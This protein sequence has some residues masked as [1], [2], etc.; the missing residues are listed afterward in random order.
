MWSPRLHP[1]LRFRLRTQ[2]HNSYRYSCPLLQVCT[3]FFV[4]ETL[5]LS[6][7]DACKLCVTNVLSDAVL[8]CR[9][10]M[11]WRVCRMSQCVTA[12]NLHWTMILVRLLGISWDQ[13]ELFGINGYARSCFLV[14]NGIETVTWSQSCHWDAGATSNQFF[15]AWMNRSGGQNAAGK[16]LFHDFNVMC[17]CQVFQVGKDVWCNELL[18]LM[19]CVWDYASLTQCWRFVGVWCV[20]CSVSPAPRRST[21]GFGGAIF[22]I[23]TGSAGA[24]PWRSH[25]DPFGFTLLG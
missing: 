18:C 19:W 17:V 20:P 16:L 7:T 3:R 11:V 23:E 24:W 5:M 9:S 2:N 14:Q 4:D 15:R 13:F 22:Q 10:E 6:V 25:L 8:L 1:N 12:K 21:H